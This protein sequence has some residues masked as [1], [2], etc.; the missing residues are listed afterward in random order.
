MSYQRAFSNCGSTTTVDLNLN[1]TIVNSPTDPL[2]HV[3]SWFVHA[4]NWSPSDLPPHPPLHLPTQL[5]PDLPLDFVHFVA[6]SQWV[7]G[8]LNLIVDQ[9]PPLDHPPD[10]QICLTCSIFSPHPCQSVVTLCFPQDAC[11]HVGS[12]GLPRNLLSKAFKI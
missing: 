12:I 8:E 1:C 9:Q 3:T 7:T 5:G 4:S 11:A 10:R 6:K 2:P